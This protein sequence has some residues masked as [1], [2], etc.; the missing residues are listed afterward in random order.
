MLLRPRNHGQ[1]LRPQ[2][3]WMESLGTVLHHIRNRRLLPEGSLDNTHLLRHVRLGQ[4]PCVHVELRHTTN[5][6]DGVSTCTAVPRTPESDDVSCTC[7]V[8]TSHCQ[9]PRVFIPCRFISRLS[10][11]I[12]RTNLRRTCSHDGFI[13]FVALPASLS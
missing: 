13:F 9:A 12:I 8:T 11:D 4:L 10:S 7:D 2:L 5:I 1:E 6:T 3:V